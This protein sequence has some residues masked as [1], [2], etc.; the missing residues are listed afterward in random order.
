MD[1]PLNPVSSTLFLEYASSGKLEELQFVLSLL[2]F[3]AP[4]V[5]F[6][7]NFVS[8]YIYFNLQVS[9]I[10]GGIWKGASQGSEQQQ[11]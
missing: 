9:W 2:H 1:M 8:H 4:E 6:C 11:K 3:S 7:N 5:S 10:S